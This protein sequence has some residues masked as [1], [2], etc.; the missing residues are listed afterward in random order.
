MKEQDGYFSKKP[1]SEKADISYDSIA[2]EPDEET[3]ELVALVSTIF[4]KEDISNDV[5]LLDFG[6]DHDWSIPSI[7]VRSSIEKICLLCKFLLDDNNKICLPCK[8]YLD[9]NKKSACPAKIIWMTQIKF[10]C[11]AKIIW[12][13][14]KKLHA[15]QKLFG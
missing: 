14:I 11:P 7:K 9:D 6:L 1:T 12:T 13:S 8:N 15:L 5:L 10:A 3:K 2:C 4:A